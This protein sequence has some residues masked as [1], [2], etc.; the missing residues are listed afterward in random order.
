MLVSG[1]SVSAR[2]SACLSARW[3]NDQRVGIDRVV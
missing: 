2:V 1:V 3:S